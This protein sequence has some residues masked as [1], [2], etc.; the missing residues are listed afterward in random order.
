MKKNLLLYG[1]VLCLLLALT[2]CG[3]ETAEQAKGADTITVTDSIGRE[4]TV[5]YPLTRVVVSNAYNAE[6][7]NAVGALDTVVG[8]DNYIF[9][10]EAGFKGKFKR[11]QVI[12]ANQ[13]NLNYEKIIELQPQ[14]LIL[15]GNGGWEDAAEKLEKF[16]IAVIVVDAYYTREFQD[17]CMLIGKRL[18]QAA[19]SE[20]AEEGSLFRVPHG[21]Q[22]DGAGR[23]LL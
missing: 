12:G 14:A 18:H 23:L 8:V 10:D 15:T 6:L 19:D 17:N 3:K 9:N 22:D 4:V 11:D 20:C 21:G 5:P 16:G 2:G 7:I 1:L 13:G